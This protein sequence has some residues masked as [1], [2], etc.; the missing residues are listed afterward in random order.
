[1]ADVAAAAAQRLDLQ[2]QEVHLAQQ[3]GVE[4]GA[5]RGHHQPRRLPGVPR[6]RPGCGPRSV[7]RGVA[8]PAPEPRLELARQPVGGV[9]EQGPG[10]PAAP[11]AV[12]PGLKV[13][14]PTRHGVE[15]G[16]RSGAAP[17]EQVEGARR[18]LPPGA[19]LADDEDRQGAVRGAVQEGG[20]VADG[21]AGAELGDAHAAGRTTVAGPRTGGQLD[22]VADGGEAA[23]EA[24]V[25]R[26]AA[27]RDEV[28]RQREVRGRGAPVAHRD[29][30]R[31]S[32][33]STSLASRRAACRAGRPPASAAVSTSTRAA[34]A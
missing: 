15:D 28:L 22:A 27:Q 6:R 20:E 7:R 29:A 11:P 25:R 4:G 23:P 5:G 14:A 10:A 12:Q 30:P 32:R 19:R 16:E 1:M 2:A 17:I 8:Q 9:E 31:Y 3:A 21:V 33:A 34:A 13:R 24:A 18:V 26:L